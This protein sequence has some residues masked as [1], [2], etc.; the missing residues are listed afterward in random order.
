[1]KQRLINY[2]KFWMGE[3]SY[4]RTLTMIYLKMKSEKGK[5]WVDDNVSYESWQTGPE[6]TGI[7]M[8]SRFV[9][10]IIDAAEADGLT[11]DDIFFIKPGRP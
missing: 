2:K 5:K 7:Y 6:R 8:E 3:G 10:N 1:M 9:E 4:K 11:P